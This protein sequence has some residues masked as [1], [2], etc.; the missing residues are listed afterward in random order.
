MTK[1]KLKDAIKEFE[2]EYDFGDGWRHRIVVEGI[3]APTPYNDWPL[4]LTG[5]NAC[6]PEDIGGPSGFADFVQSMADPEDDDHFENWNWYGGPFDPKGFD[7]NTTNA[8]I[9]NLR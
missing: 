2:Y 6:P 1:V 7:V 3:M 4:C 5:E 9:R 8:R